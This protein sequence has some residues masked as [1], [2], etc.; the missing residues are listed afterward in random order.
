M[1]EERANTSNADA[2]RETDTDDSGF[3]ITGYHVFGIMVLAFGTIIGVNLFMAVSAV[4][5]FP[6]LEVKNSYVASQTFDDEKAAQDALGW[7]VDAEAQGETFRVEITDAAG[8]P[9]KVTSLGGTLGRPTSVVDDQTPAF[10]FDGSTYVATTGKLDEGNWNYRM[11][12]EAADGTEF[13]RRIVFYVK[14]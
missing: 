7:R 8:Q 10:T 11:V 13:K 2:K 3:R 4:K 12:A 9:V 1:T 14:H 5:T 6:G